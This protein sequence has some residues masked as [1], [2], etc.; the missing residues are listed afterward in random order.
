VAFIEIRLGSVKEDN[1][2]QQGPHPEEVLWLISVKT[3]FVVL[4]S[5]ICQ[6]AVKKNPVSQIRF[7]Q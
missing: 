3:T 1:V 6:Y 4:H 7:A 2:E 5:E